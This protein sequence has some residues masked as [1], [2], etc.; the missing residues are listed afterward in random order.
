MKI[1]NQLFGTAGGIIIGIMM[2]LVVAEVT[3]R[4]FWGSSIEGAIEIEGVSL[5]L[6][7]FF[8][9]SPCEERKNH[10]RAEFM[11]AWLPKKIKAS[12]DIVVY[13]AAILVVAVVTW[14]V[15]LDMASSWSIKEV[16]PGA[17]WQVPVYPAKAAA[18]LG[19][20]AF[21]IQLT[22]NLV[23]AIKTQR[24]GRAKI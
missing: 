14:Q 11:A 4:L 18:F 8:G 16:L 6:A 3:S 17:R 21:F 19:Y 10:V 7:I 20:F 15:G 1:V 5:A 24:K 13:L 23:K 12:L 2:L 9:F 22:V